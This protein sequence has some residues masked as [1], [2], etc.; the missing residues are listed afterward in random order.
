MNCIEINNLTKTYGSKTI[1]LD[2]LDLVVQR[3]KIV[4]F[5]GPNGAGKS[6]TINII[7][8]MVQKDG[9]NVEIFGSRVGNNDYEF[10]R[11]VGFV[12]ERPIYF[13]KLSVYEHLTFLASMY[14]IEKNDARS[15]TEELIEFFDLA[16]RQNDW[17]EKYSA[18][19]KKRVS[20]AAALVHKPELLVL[21]EPLD[22]IDPI[23]AKRIKDL[24]KDFAQIN[25]T[26]LISSH[27]LDTI[28]R[29]C[30]EVAIVNKGKLVF[31]SGT[32]DIRNRVKSGVTRKTY[33]T[34]EEIF[35]DAVSDEEVGEEKK[36]LSWL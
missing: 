17:I 26:I 22:G 30:D 34:L 24:L 33:Q 4:G 27:N 1:A 3:G 21:D 32:G 10:K 28:E 2:G 29:I 23:I 35:V 18:G 16:D 11:R 13:D 31:Q 19:M 8:G 5:L 20:L 14:G 7:A 25:G 36:K 12:L 15:R 6:T 9:G